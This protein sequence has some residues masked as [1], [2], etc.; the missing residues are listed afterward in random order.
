MDRGEDHAE[1]PVPLEVILGVVGTFDALTPHPQQLLNH[2]LTDLQ[3]PSI[4]LD[5]L[6][7]PI[8]LPPLLTLL[9]LTSISPCS[10]TKVE[11]FLLQ[12][13]LLHKGFVQNSSRVA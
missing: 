10:I 4:M 7:Q 5:P 9:T 1:G 11:H 8:H 2:T 12:V 13:E 3:G 6:F